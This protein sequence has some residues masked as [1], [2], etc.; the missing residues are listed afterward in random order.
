[1]TRSGRR[2]SKLCTYR[3]KPGV[4]FHWNGDQMVEEIPVGTDST[5]DNENAIRWIYEP[6]SFIPLARYEKDQLH[7]VVTDSVGRIQEL[8]TEDGEIA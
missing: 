3:D 6:D 8:L 4:H 7:Y 1:M 2:I 5:A